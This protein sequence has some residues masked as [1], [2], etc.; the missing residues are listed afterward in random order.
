M[1]GSERETGPRAIKALFKP[2]T[3]GLYAPFMAPGAVMLTRQPLAMLEMKY[4]SWY[5]VNFVERLTRVAK[6]VLFAVRA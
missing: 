6:S 1:E 2:G 3:R 5:V 4:A